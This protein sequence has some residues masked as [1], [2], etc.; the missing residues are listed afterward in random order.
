MTR[1]SDA[2]SGAPIPHPPTPKTMPEQRPQ[3]WHVAVMA[4]SVAN[5]T[6]QLVFHPLDTLKT[7]FQLIVRRA[8]LRQEARPSLAALTTKIV[9]EE[10]VWGGLYRGVGPALGKQPVRGAIKFGSNQVYRERIGLGAAAA[11]TASGVTECLFLTPF[12]FLKVRLMAGDRTGQ[13]FGQVVRQALADGGGGPRA[14]WSGLE[15]TC[16]RN[17]LWNGAYF[18]VLGAIEIERAR[19]R[20]AAAADDDDDDDDGNNNRRESKSKLESFLHGTVAGSVG[21]VFSNPFDVVKSRVQNA[22]E[23]ALAVARGGVGSE[24]GSAGG[25]SGGGGLGGRGAGCG[26]G[27][28]AGADG[29]AGG[30]ARAGAG[31]GARAGAGAGARAGA[32]ARAGAG[33]RAGAALQLPWAL[34]VLV[35]ILRAEGPR[36]LY[37]GFVPKILRLGP[38]GGCLLLAFDTAKGWMREGEGRE[39]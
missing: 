24:G 29:G 3:P 14:F 26:A 22:Q 6:E 32:R 17:G 2:S 21:S 5:S 8:Q 1:A 33:A 28:G 10:G 35:D 30:G 4:G 16:W 23:E 25:G 11:G 7:R 34:P 18:G 36:A 38:G 39:E 19:A 31:A 13:S 20:A 37:A 15:V 9:K 12:E 27:A